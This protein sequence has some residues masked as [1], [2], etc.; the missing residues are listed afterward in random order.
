V[1]TKARH[2]SVPTHGSYG[3]YE[4]GEYGLR[5]SACT[6]CVFAATRGGLWIGP[7]EGFPPT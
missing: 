3:E 2:V 1:W 6:G 4:E 7:F 5:D